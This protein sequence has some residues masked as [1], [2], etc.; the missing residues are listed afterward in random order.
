MDVVGLAYFFTPLPH[1]EAG[2]IPIYIIPR[3]YTNTAPRMAIATPN[4][5]EQ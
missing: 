4:N 1:R 5:K 3:D 2:G